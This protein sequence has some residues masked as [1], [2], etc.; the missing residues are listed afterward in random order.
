LNDFFK[1]NHI[2][3][4]KQ[5]ITQ[6]SIKTEFVVEMNMLDSIENLLNR[7]GYVTSKDYVYKDNDEVIQKFVDEIAR[8]DEV[9]RS[10]EAVRSDENNQKT[11]VNKQTQINNLK[12]NRDKSYISLSVSE[13]DMVGD[14]VAF[15]TMPGFEYGV[16]FTENPK[17]GLSAPLYQTYTL[18]FLFTRGKSYFLLSMLKAMDY[19]HTDLS[20]NTEYFMLNFGQDFYTRHLGRGK[21]RYF[22]PYM[23]YQ[24]GGFL[25]NNEK[26]DNKFIMNVNT[27]LGIEFIKT[28]SFLLDS[29]V[30]YFLPIHQS[31]INMR[32]IQVGI[33][34]NLLF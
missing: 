31:N 6:R 3:I 20:L 22:N 12:R 15:V 16:L 9:V 11:I 19:D 29:K 27:A 24:F 5:N 8:L 23:G 26:S 2:K 17:A 25:A 7:L 10:E 32:G 28:R 1:D 30:S 18:K 34:A 4:L 14:G 21:R 13:E 33:S